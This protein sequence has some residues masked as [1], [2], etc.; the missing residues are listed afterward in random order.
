M[1]VQNIVWFRF[2]EFWDFW[3]LS[4]SR[5]LIL[6]QC[7]TLQPHFILQIFM[8]FDGQRKF[9]SE[10][11]VAFFDECSIQWRSNCAAAQSFFANSG[12]RFCWFAN[13]WLVATL[14]VNYWRDAMLV[15]D[16]KWNSFAIT[17][18][19]GRATSWILHSHLFML[20][21]SRNA[22]DSISLSGLNVR[23]LVREWS[24]SFPIRG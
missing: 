12:S 14:L 19:M 3:S 8:V 24:W 2:V 13:H 18:L 9:A 23:Y 6:I 7:E 5:Y 4:M 17:S 10:M 16:I 21:G 11:L 20:S 15:L 1:A 22:V